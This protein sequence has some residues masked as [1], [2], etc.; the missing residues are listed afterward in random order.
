MEHTMKDYIQ[1]QPSVLAAMLRD[2]AALAAPFAEF[3]TQTRPDRL[4]IVGS[5]TSQ[6][7]AAAASAFLTDLLQ[8]EVTPVIPTRLPAIFGSRP[9]VVFLSQGGSS[10]NMLAA[11]E[12][13]ARYPAIAITGEAACEISR[14]SK[15]H[16]QIG[17]GEELAGPKT[18][19][20]TASVLCLY[21]CALEA[22]KGR[23]ISSQR[24]AEEVAALEVAFSQMPENLRRCRRWLAQNQETL[25]APD[26]FLFVGQGTGAFAA[27]EAAL[28]FLET[29]RLPAMGYEFEEYLHGP[30]L[31]AN[32]TLG[33]LLFLTQD[34]GLR[35]RMEG[36]ARC[37]AAEC[38]AF[39]AVA[40]QPVDGVPTLELLQ[41][42][43]STTEVFEFI[44]PAQMAAADLPARK[45]VSEHCR[46][47]EQ[48]TKT[49]QTKYAGGR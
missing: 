41:T 30:L 43:S 24:Y 6:N 11:M 3:F 15:L 38:P 25:L 29:L 12:Q 23:T 18:L 5:G 27:Q 8:I 47:E 35:P 33:G 1:Q 39:F 46:I 22:A 13:L 37:Q 28:K 31:V 9:A 49:W 19:G 40:G 48:F 36:L 42:G 16:M 26:R 34:P 45:G 21:L 44:L 2:R 32:W 14:R 4:Y 7:A 17:C 20:Y 10:T